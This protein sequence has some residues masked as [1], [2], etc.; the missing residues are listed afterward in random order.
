LLSISTCNRYTKWSAAGKKWVVFFQD[1]NSLVFR[2]VPGAL[3][4]SKDK[5]FVFNSLCVPRKAKEAIGG[6]LH[7]LNVYVECTQVECIR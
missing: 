3:G 6:A 1:T 5:G 4:V 2:V 7:K